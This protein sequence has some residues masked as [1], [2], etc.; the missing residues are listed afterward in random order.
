MKNKLSNI[1]IIF[2]F[3][4][5]CNN[6]FAQVVI[7]NGI[8]F[9]A[10]ARDANN[11]AASN[12]NIYAIVNILEKTTNG[13]SVFSESF[14]VVSSQ[15]GIF[16]IVIG[17]G[18][19]LSGVASLTDIN[20]TK[21]LHFV[22]IKIAIEPTLYNPDW[23]PSNNYVD[24]GTSQLWAVPYSLSAANANFSDSSDNPAI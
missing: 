15:E 11:N 1:L 10:V 24:I 19:R 7:P 3:T 16:S 4:F 23:S 13:N 18:A 22:N 2:I 8:L 5:Y 9:Q 17:Q 20:W 6:A 14:K 12:R 21:N